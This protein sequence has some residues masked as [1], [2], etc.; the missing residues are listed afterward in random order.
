MFNKLISNLKAIRYR[1][2][3]LTHDLLVIPLA[4]MIAYWLRYNLSH[5]PDEFL[6]HAA[7]LLVIVIPIQGATLLFFGLFPAG[8]F[9]SFFEYFC[10]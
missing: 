3:V 9:R 4:W 1:W 5:I 6:A 7:W 8:P 2:L 10:Y